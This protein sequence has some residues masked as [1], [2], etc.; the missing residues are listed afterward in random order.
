MGEGD[1]ERWVVDVKTTGAKPQPV[2]Q[3]A[4]NPTEEGKTGKPLGGNLD[5]VAYLELE[6]P[7]EKVPAIRYAS[8]DPKLYDAIVNMCVERDKMCMSEMMSIDKQGG[9][10]LA[11]LDNLAP[12]LYGG[13]ERNRSVFGPQKTYVAA[14][15]ST[16][17]AIAMT[18]KLPQN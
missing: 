5:R 14:I 11:G 16:E 4:D 6:K 17:E 2:G 12:A 8:V 10:G 18:A 7:S 3:N 1:F 13:G 9:L 15:C